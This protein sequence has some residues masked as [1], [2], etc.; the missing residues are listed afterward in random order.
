MNAY[1]EYLAQMLRDFFRDLGEFFRKGIVSPWTDVGNN[2]NKY[3]SNLTSHSADF[4]FLGWFFFVLFLLFFIALVGAVIFGLFLVIRK[5]I[6]F[7]RRE[8]DNDAQRNEIARL[9]YELYTATQEKDKILNLKSAYMGITPADK[10]ADEAMAEIN[11]RF[12]KLATV[13]AAYKVKS[14]LRA[15][16][17]PLV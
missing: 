12:P 2:F 14:T 3:H 16:L 9:N 10:M 6:R 7:V 15:K 1:F 17:N 8:I 4:H 11:S 5:Y 13:D